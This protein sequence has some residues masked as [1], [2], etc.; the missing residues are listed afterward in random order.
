MGEEEKLREMLRRIAQEHVPTM[1]LRRIA[2][3]RPC[4]DG[5]FP[6]ISEDPMLPFVLFYSVN[7]PS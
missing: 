1:L 6:C 4:P 2:G 3:A 5:V 7:N